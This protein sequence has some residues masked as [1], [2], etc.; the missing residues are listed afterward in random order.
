MRKPWVQIL[1][2][3]DINEIAVRLPF[4]RRAEKVQVEYY[5]HNPF[6]G[7]EILS[8]RG[9]DFLMGKCSKN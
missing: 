8:I 7:L 9:K 5:L 4:S 6:N 3:D 2:W 1:M